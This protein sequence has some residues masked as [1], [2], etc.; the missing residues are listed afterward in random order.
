MDEK[1]VS[2]A[3]VVIH[4]D[5]GDIDVRNA[6]GFEG[7]TEITNEAIFK[8]IEDVAERISLM[9]VEN[10]AYVGARRFYADVAAAQAAA[11]EKAE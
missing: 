7:A 2:V 4:Y 11:A 3:Y 8:D 10:A 5:N 1:K 9:R 6:D